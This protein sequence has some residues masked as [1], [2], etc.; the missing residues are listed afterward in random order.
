MYIIKNAF[1]NMTRNKGK[2][3]LIGVIITVITICT[4][5]SLAIHK[6][7]NNLVLSYKNTNPLAISFN[8]NM[9]EL[10]NASDEDKNNFE[11]ISIDD[12]KEYGDSNYIKDYY[13]TL[14]ASLNSDD[15]EAI[16]DN[17]RPEKPEG[18]DDGFRKNDKMIGNMGD[19]RITAYSNFAY[20]SEFQDGTKKISDGIM[21]TGNDDKNEI[22]I[23]KALAEDNDLEVGDEITF[24]LPDDDGITFDFEIIGIYED[25]SESNASS[26]MQMNALNSS[27]QL[28][29]N[30]TVLQDILDEQGEDSSKLIA[31]NGL[32][33]KFYL[34]SN[35]D[36]NKF[37]KEVKDKGL[38]DYYEIMTNENE[39]LETLQPI[40][41]ISSFSFN[42]LIVVFIIG[43]VV[44]SVINFLNIR[45]R[46]YEIGVLRAIGMNKTK[47]TTQLVL[48]L[49][50]VAMASLIIGTGIGI[51]TSQPVTNKILENEIESYTTKEEIT[52]ENFG[53]S[54]MMRPSQDMQTPPDDNQP[55]RRGGMF[56]DMFGKNK[57]KDLDYVDS[58]TVT[59]DLITILQLAGI[60]I[61]LTILSGSVASIVVNQYNPNKILQ[62]RV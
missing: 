37:T 20:L 51:I 44:L 38:S 28:Y 57:N 2:N 41:N 32:S 52:T 23:S 8:V 4:C 34:K 62:N 24:Y 40:Q 6:A 22:V 47:V 36:L 54:D 7:G 16:V 19:F 61:L 42:F 35:D 33:A 12:I 5:I 49:F 18:E 30:V 10:R 58:L 26:F 21:V 50:F 17:E 15:V 55:G 3:I 29:T 13:Y 56:N 45:D 46:K 39:I 14:E 60:T 1:R 11:S 31:S 25:S 9:H 59:I 27:N 43:V 48:E 53:R